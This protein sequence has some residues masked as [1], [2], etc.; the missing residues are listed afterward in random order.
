MTKDRVE[1]FLSEFSDW[2][3]GQS[4]IQTVALVGS[5]AS[6]TAIDGSDVDLVV[7]AIQPG[8][9]LQDLAWVWAYAK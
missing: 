7:V 8:M 4:D 2:A 9:Y 1:R 3:F 5:Y 6:S